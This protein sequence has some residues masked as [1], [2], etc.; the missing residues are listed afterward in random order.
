MN[1]RLRRLVDRLH[2]KS[3]QGEVA[4]RKG[5]SGAFEVSFPRYTIAL[6]ESGESLVATLT[7]YNDEGEVLDFVTEN[8]FDVG[9]LLIRTPDLDFQ[10]K[11]RET[12]RM[13]RRTAL[14]SD[15][16]IENLLAELEN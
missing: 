2:E 16:A 4:W 15:Q 12:Y 3:S 14:G 13:A 1:E 7:I 5:A 8:S 6:N 10:R 11:L 9:G